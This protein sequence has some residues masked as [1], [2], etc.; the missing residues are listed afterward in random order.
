MT[1][2]NF[3]AS[4]E[5]L[6]L[7]SESEIASLAGSFFPEPKDCPSVQAGLIS[8]ADAASFLDE[9]QKAFEL[10]SGDLYPADIV[11]SSTT[12][13]GAPVSYSPNVISMAQVE[14]NNSVEFSPSSP[15]AKTSHQESVGG[16]K[17]NSSMVTLSRSIMT[18]VICIDAAM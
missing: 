16:Q 12:N 6:G 11:P 13:N 9:A 1:T 4:P 15:E 14:Q 2:T 7:P 8:E 18:H 3:F 17:N 10:A 5:S